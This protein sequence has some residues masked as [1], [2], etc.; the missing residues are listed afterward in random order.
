MLLVEQNIN[1]ITLHLRD[2]INNLKKLWKIELAIAID[3]TS[4]QDNDGECLIESYN[5]EIMVNDKADEMSK[6]MLILIGNINERY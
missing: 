5:I 1:N 6:Q 2:I 4:S 3:F